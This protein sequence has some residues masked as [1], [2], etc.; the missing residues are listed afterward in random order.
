MPLLSIAQKKTKDTAKVHLPMKDGLIFY[1]RVVDNLSSTKITLYNTSLKWMAETFN[2]AKEVIQIQDK[3]S[4]TITGSGNF[5]YFVPGFIS[6]EGV[7]SF[8]IDINLKDNKSRIRLYQFANLNYSGGVSSRIPIDE[9]YKSYLLEMRFPK[10]NKKRYEILA[11]KIEGIL[12][13][14]V[15]YIKNKSGKDDF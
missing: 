15:N 3:D 2:D 11:S 1:E 10:E 5:R 14:Y 9:T 13:S 12:I 7:V 8:I 4:G 6:E